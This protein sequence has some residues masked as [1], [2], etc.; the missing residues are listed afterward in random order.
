MCYCGL[1]MEFSE[2]CREGFALA[3]TVAGDASA[4]D[5]A[6]GLTPSARD[7]LMRLPRELAQATSA[8]RQAR[9]RQMVAHTVAAQATAH[10]DSTHQ[11]RRVARGL[12]WLASGT[13]PEQGR[14]W[15]A[16]AASLPRAGFLPEPALLS[17]LRRIAARPVRQ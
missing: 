2:R 5:A 11:G 16:A 15:L 1:D 14:T 17:L 13:A 4:A 12:A 6:P 3:A 9:V 7:L 8:Q 10:T